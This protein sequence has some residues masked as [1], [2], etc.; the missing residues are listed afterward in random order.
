MLGISH[1]LNPS[2]SPD[3]A[4][5]TFLQPLLVVPLPH[6]RGS[7]F[8]LGEGRAAYSFSYQLGKEHGPDL[9]DT[10]VCYLEGDHGGVG[11]L[12]GETLPLNEEGGKGKKRK[13]GLQETYTIAISFPSFVLQVVCKIQKCGWSF[14]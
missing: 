14:V 6:N 8:K 1:D 10:N 4:T 2:T 11:R 5:N 12:E 9:I 7:V 3:L 13:L